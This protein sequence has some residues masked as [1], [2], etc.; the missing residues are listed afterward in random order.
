MNCEPLAQ[1]RHAERGRAWSAPRGGAGTVGIEPPAPHV[2][3][4]GGGPALG[5]EYLVSCGAAEQLK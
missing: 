2:G 3:R 4:L 1:A 5:P